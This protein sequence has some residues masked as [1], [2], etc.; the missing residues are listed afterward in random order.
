[1]GSAT[2]VYTLKL[3]YIYD[4][5]LFD[6]NIVKIT[7]CVKNSPIWKSCLSVLDPKGSHFQPSLSSAAAR[8]VQLKSGTLC[9]L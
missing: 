8:L 6:K 3:V 4:A 1:M 9:K 2:N 7:F 5:L